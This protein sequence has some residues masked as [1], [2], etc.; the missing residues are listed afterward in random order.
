MFTF[1]D[2]LSMQYTFFTPF[3]KNNH[4]LGRISY[5]SD[6]PY[7]TVLSKDGKNME[8]ISNN[9]GHVWQLI[10]EY[11]T[12]TL[13]HKHE[14]DQEYHFQTIIGNFYDVVLYIVGHD[15]YQ[16]RNRNT[17]SVDEEKKSDSYFWRLISQ[18][19]VT[20]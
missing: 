1:E 17:V 10:Y 7:F 19:G 20:A 11:D 18:Y 2:L 6:K 12:Y 15:E 5:I 13:M 3:Y 9:T 4:K 14:K 8:L 16:M